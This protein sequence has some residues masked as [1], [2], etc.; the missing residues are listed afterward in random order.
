LAEVVVTGGT[1]WYFEDISPVSISAGETFFVGYEVD[2][3]SGSYLYLDTSSPVNVGP[4]TVN[5]AS[6]NS[7]GSCP[8]RVN[9]SVVSPVDVTFCST[10]PIAAPEN[11]DKIGDRYCYY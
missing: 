6:Y 3:S 2:N 1:G 4:Y 8:S 5:F 9:G 10:N 11:T 7:V